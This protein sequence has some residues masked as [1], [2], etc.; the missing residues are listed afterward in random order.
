[1]ASERDNMKE[2]KIVKVKLGPEFTDKYKQIVSVLL[3]G[4]NNFFFCLY[5]YLYEDEAK[6]ANIRVSY[7]HEASHEIL[8]VGLYESDASEIQTEVTYKSF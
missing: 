5:Q 8:S 2:K 1:M 4:H 7:K 3:L 6:D